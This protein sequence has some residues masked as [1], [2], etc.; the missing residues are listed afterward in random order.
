MAP[1]GPTSISA[2]TES[3]ARQRSRRVLRASRDAG[4]SSPDRLLRQASD[5]RRAGDAD[6]AVGLYRRIQQDFPKS[7]QAVL[8]SVALGGLLLDRGLPRAALGQFDA[9][10][11]SSRG[12]VLIPEALYGR[13][14]ALAVLGD[15][16]E[17]R[18]TWDRL[19]ADFPKSAYG[20]LARRRLADLK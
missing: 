5:A 11:A 12:G 14:R 4:A 9:Y 20:P 3:G 19:L 17:E 15:R 18:Q 7:S 10:L 16:R 8:S 13:G 1:V 2:T 6:R